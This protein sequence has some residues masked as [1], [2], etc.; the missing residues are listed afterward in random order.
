MVILGIWNSN[1]GHFPLHLLCTDM[2]EHVSC[3]SQTMLR[4]NETDYPSENSHQG[5]RSKCCF[6]W[7]SVRW[8]C[9]HD[10][11]ASMSLSKPWCIHSGVLRQGE[12]TASLCLR[13]FSPCFSQQLCCIGSLWRR[14]LINTGSP[15]QR[16]RQLKDSTVN[17]LHRL[18]NVLIKGWCQH[19]VAN[20]VQ[21]SPC[22][23]SSSRVHEY[24]QSINQLADQ[25]KSQI[26][27]INCSRYT[28]SGN[29][30]FV[31]VLLSQ[32]EQFTGSG[33]LGGQNKQINVI[34][35]GSMYLRWQFINT[36]IKNIIKT[37]TLWSLLTREELS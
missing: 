3:F 32:N 37:V 5:H 28:S 29:E 19:T 27:W 16:S 12:G 33:L 7:I 25:P 13:L 10:C 17:V 8:W 31:M 9:L 6:W 18:C 23:L 20:A 15:G 35:L 11:D 2:S 30:T 34:K 26:K 22:C 36:K 4:W 14:D 21:P 1:Q 24:T